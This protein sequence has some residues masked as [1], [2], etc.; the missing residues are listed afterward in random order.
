M[1]GGSL[2]DIADLLGHK[3]ITQTMIYT[4]L[5]ESHTRGVVERMGEKFLSNP[6][7]GGD[8]HAGL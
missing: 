1:A 6:G 4:H 7:T 5:L 3:N 2:R 8:A